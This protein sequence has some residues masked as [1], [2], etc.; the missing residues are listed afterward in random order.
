MTVLLPGMTEDDNRVK[1]SSAEDSQGL[2]ESWKSK[3]FRYFL[4]F[5]IIN[6]T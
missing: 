4:L 1:V 3:V 2:L 6:Y 5:D